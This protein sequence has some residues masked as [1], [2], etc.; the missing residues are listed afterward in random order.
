MVVTKGDKITIKASQS[1]IKAFIA[2]ITAK[3]NNELVAYETSHTDNDSTC[4][5][6]VWHQKWKTLLGSNLPT[7]TSRTALSKVLFKTKDVKRARSLVACVDKLRENLPL[8]DFYD[9]TVSPVN[10]DV[11][12]MSPKKDT[13]ADDD[14][15]S[16]KEKEGKVIT[17]EDFTTDDDSKQLQTVLR[18]ATTWKNVERKGS[19]KFV[20]AQ[21]HHDQGNDNDGNSVNSFSVL[22][23]T[24][25]GTGNDDTGLSY[26]TSNDDDDAVTVY[27]EDDDESKQQ[28]PTPKRSGSHINITPIDDKSNQSVI[29]SVQSRDTSSGTIS[30]NDQKLNLSTE[31]NAIIDNAINSNTVDQLDQDLLM[32]WINSSSHKMNDTLNKNMLSL[33]KHSKTIKS[34]INDQIRHTAKAIADLKQHCDKN[35][36][37][38]KSEVQKVVNEIHDSEMKSIA[39]I[40]TVCN[41]EKSS[42]S[43]ITSESQD[44]LYK[45]T[46]TVKIAQTAITHLADINNATE[47]YAD[48]LKEEMI[49]FCDTEKDEFV[50]WAGE[51]YKHYKMDVDLKMEL[52]A[53]RELLQHERLQMEKERDRTERV[54]LDMMMRLERLEALENK[55]QDR[56]TNAPPATM[57][58]QQTNTKNNPSPPPVKQELKPSPIL[59]K[60]TTVPSPISSQ[61]HLPSTPS[62]VTLK[63]PPIQ[64][65]KYNDGRIHPLP[66]DTGIH[67]KDPLHDIFGLIMGDNPPEFK[68]GYWHHDICTIN[69]THLQNCSEEHMNVRA[70]I[71]PASIKKRPSNQRSHY[72]RVDHDL[73][74]DDPFEDEEFTRP[75]AKS[76]SPNRRLKS[77][78]FIYPHGNDPKYVLTAYLIRQA[79]KWNI[80]LDELGI[81]QF[82]EFLKSRCMQYNIFLREYSNITLNDNLAAITPDNCTNYEMALKE[83]STAMYL[84]LDGNKSRWMSE[85]SQAFQSLKAYSTSCD[86]LAYLKNIMKKQHPALKDVRSTDTAEKP[87]FKNCKD[88]YSFINDYIYWLDEEK[89]RGRTYKNEEKIYWVLNN[90]DDRFKTAKDIMLD[91]L[92]NNIFLHRQNPK[93]LPVDYFV[94]ESLSVYIV[95][96]LK[97]EEQEVDLT[98]EVPTTTTPRISRTATDRKPY[99]LRSRNTPPRTPKEDYRKKI[100]KDLKWELKPGEFCPGCGGA[101]HNIYETGCPTF[102]RYAKCKAFYD[103]FNDKREFK[104]IMEAYDNYQQTRQK[105][106]KADRNKRRERLKRLV[107]EDDCSPEG[108]E[109]M[110]KT[111]FKDYKE[112]NEDE[113]FLLDNPFDSLELESLADEEEDEFYQE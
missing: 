62:K 76:E 61:Q 57:Y 73:T 74:N 78:E 37:N 69:G 58:C 6:P 48:N 25:D 102:A 85:Q 43:E 17:R 3:L 93:P 54:R 99:N 2:T 55:F 80:S 12:I 70:D 7:C 107:D 101:N 89:L 9:F 27:D 81:R 14:P 8:N 13:L 95:G 5:P 86:G 30:S 63:K 72:N 106:L 84:L 113:R 109:F 15:E 46:N 82:Y 18:D 50:E 39:A 36:H 108:L 11:Y 60:K 64:R 111:Y 31:E 24:P 103:K 104:P 105:T 87:Q 32:R 51:K 77:N 75:W 26:D 21:L 98:N 4:K 66:I 96:L 20:N 45:L 44:L 83:M 22:E 110:K 19:A 33:T 92:D 49:Q 90:L 100:R 91:K 65:F 35:I 53:E 52:E 68:N 1:H 79:E 56:E 67:Y 94:T 38:A 88:I 71:T 34:N 47:S 40:H 41:T 10:K 42:F 29:S 16:P 112:D 59:S 97:P 23:P 28:D